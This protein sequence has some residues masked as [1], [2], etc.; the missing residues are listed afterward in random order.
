MPSLTKT[1][2]ARAESPREIG[3]SD[4]SAFDGYEALDDTLLLRRIEESGDRKT[5][6]GI[7]LPDGV[8]GA[9]EDASVRYEVVMRGPGRKPSEGAVATGDRLPCRSKVGDTVIVSQLA[10]AP[11]QFAG[12]ALYVV[13]DSKVQ[14]LKRERV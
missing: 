6:G 11:V 2:T 13:S 7:H 12:E 9:N 5:I 8:T 14:F 10:C 3:L 1:K 4:L